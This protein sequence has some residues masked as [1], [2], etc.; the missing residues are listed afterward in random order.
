ML[1]VVSTKDYH[2]DDDGEVMLLPFI[3]VY[4]YRAG[5]AMNWLTC[6]E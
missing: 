3:I 4:R 5:F 1:A 2:I 6:K